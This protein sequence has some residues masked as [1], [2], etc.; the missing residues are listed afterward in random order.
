LLLTLQQAATRLGKSL[1]QVRYMVTRG[2]LGAR[3]VEGRWVIDDSALPASEGQRQAADRRRAG[4]A[5]AVEDAL[6]LGHEGRRRWSLRDLQAFKVG[7][8]LYRDT[9]GILGDAHP[10]ALALRQSLAN[11]ARGCHRFAHGE[12]L[13][14][15]QQARDAASDAAFELAL[16]QANAAPLVDRVEQDYLAAVAGLLRRNERRPRA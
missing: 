7:L 13:S 5:A 4:L 8:P 12:K 3:K 1:R 10:A 14:A 9:C 11:L 2:E 16:A 15:Y 6:D